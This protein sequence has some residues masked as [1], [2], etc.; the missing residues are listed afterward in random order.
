MHWCQLPP[1][2]AGMPGRLSRH[3]SSLI[4]KWYV[5]TSELVF[6]TTCS[7][8]QDGMET[9]ST[10]PHIDGELITVSPDIISI[11]LSDPVHGREHSL[12]LHSLDYLWLCIAQNT[13]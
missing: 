5:G 9:W 4:N 11:K 8:P 1:A 13:T 6:V 12:A 3:S 10:V 7:I 2:I